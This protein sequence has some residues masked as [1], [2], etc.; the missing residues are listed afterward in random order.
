MRIGKLE[1]TTGPTERTGMTVINKELLVEF[2]QKHADAGNSIDNWVAHVESTIW[3]TSQDIKK[4]FRSASLLA[5][6]VV[7]FNIKGNNYRLET[8]VTYNTAIV[9]VTWVGTHSEYDK[10]NKKR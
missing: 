1:D 10:R 5:K 2:K 6:N 7:I 4:I 8:K 9:K 3:R